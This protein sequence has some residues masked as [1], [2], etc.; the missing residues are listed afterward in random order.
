MSDYVYNPDS[1][2]INPSTSL[3]DLDAIEVI[4]RHSDE[5]LN[6]P[7][8]DGVMAT[9]NP[10]LTVKQQG[11]SDIKRKEITSLG[12]MSIN[13]IYKTVSK[14]F[15]DIIGDLLLLNWD[16]K[17]LPNLVGVFSKEDRL[18]TS[19]LMLVIISLFLVFTKSKKN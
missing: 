10:E 16:S 7:V 8:G 3:E 11:T 17:F 4:K 18:F 5:L 14:S 9:V 6:V 19:G 13:Q 12:D 2:E 15:F 1:Q